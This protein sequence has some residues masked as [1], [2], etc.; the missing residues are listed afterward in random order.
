MKTFLLVS[1]LSFIIIIPSFAVNPFYATVNQYDIVAKSYSKIQTSLDRNTC[2]V[3]GKVI[4]SNLNCAN[5]IPHTAPGGPETKLGHLLR[6]DRWEELLSVN[7]V[8]T[9]EGSRRY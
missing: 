3:E 9:L 2:T 5:I 4:N 1:L 6:K 8:P 7:L